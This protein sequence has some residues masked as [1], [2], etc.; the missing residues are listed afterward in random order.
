MQNSGVQNSVSQSFHIFFGLLKAPS[1]M[2]LNIS[3]D[4]AFTTSL[5]NMFQY[6]ITL[7]LKLFFLTFN[8]N[9]PSFW[10][11]TNACQLS[12]HYRPLQEVSPCL[13]YK[14]HYIN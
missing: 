1:N 12:C 9:L 2:T 6:L 14:P 8:G 7:I 4:Q 3:N 13:S 5:G 10:F 11:K